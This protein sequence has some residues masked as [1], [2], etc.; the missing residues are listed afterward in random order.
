M[1]LPQMCALDGSVKVWV[2]CPAEAG[3]VRLSRSCTALSCFFFLVGSHDCNVC[4]H[5]TKFL[6][7]CMNAD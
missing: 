6:C 1:Q 7:N 2:S 4:R 5:W 3:K